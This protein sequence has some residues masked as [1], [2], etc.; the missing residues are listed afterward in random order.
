MIYYNLILTAV[1]KI[2]SLLS[3]LIFSPLYI[4]LLGIDNYGIISASLIITGFLGIIDIGISNVITKEF[5]NKKLRLF[6]KSKII[7]TYEL[8]VFIL[9]L[10]LFLIFIIIIFFGFNFP[11]LDSIIKYGK[12]F[13]IDSFFLLLS[14]FYISALQGMQKHLHVNIIYFLRDILRTGFV[15]FIIMKIPMLEVFFI[16]QSFVTLV[17]AFYLRFLVLKNIKRKVLL[18]PFIYWKFIPNFLNNMRGISVVS[19]FSMILG[20]I[21]KISILYIAS[22]ITISEYNISSS[23]SSVMPSFGM[24]LI[25]VLLPIIM[26][27]KDGLSQKLVLDVFNV[28][29]WVLTGV[30]S[31]HVIVN[32][33]LIMTLYLQ[34]LENS[35]EYNY[36]M[37]LL[38]LAGFLSSITITT[39]ISNI[40]ADNFKNHTYIIAILVIISPFIYYVSISNNGSIGVAIAALIIQLILSLLYIIICSNDKINFRLL[41]DKIIIPILYFMLIIIFDYFINKYFGITDDISSFLIKLIPLTI[42]SLILIIFINKLWFKFNYQKFFKLI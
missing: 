17:S 16:W 22:L 18:N 34:T 26:N 13:L 2:Y 11:N 42:F 35:Q 3:L 21:D 6:S 9:F 27:I 36:Y 38:M 24:L 4:N 33:S 12:Y 40:A 31:A 41:V 14:R 20:Q 37:V 28:L 29:L 19:I 8:I 23:F 15:I 7:C 30:I 39:F 25:P 1:P 10:L 32:S 5:S